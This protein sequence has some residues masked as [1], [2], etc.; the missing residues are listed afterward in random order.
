MNK[1]DDADE[2]DEEEAKDK[3]GGDKE[4][5][6]K[7]T[8]T[9]NKVEDLACPHP[10]PHLRP[11]HPPSPPPLSF[12]PLSLPVSV[13]AESSKIIIPQV[14]IYEICEFG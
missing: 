9:L 3:E 4:D 1:E 12:P 6:E 5:E 11:P 2:G 13:N 14:L 8:K 10:S 7:T